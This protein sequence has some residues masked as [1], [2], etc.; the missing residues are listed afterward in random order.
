MKLTIDHL[1]CYLPYGVK[2]AN[3]KFIGELLTLYTTGDF[4]VSCSNWTEQLSDNKY[5]PILRPLSDLFTYP[6]YMDEY[7]DS[8]NGYLYH[9]KEDWF[10]DESGNIT[11]SLKDCISWEPKYMQK[12]LNTLYKHKFD[13]HSL[14]SQGLAI[15]IHD[16]EG[17]VY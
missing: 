11:H 8:D 16:V 9:T 17:E 14:I 5:K 7:S 1:S 12:F 10:T 6:P 3:G 2:M 15:S 13:I 4:K